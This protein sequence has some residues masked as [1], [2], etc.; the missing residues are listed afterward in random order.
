MGVLNEQYW[1]L[2]KMS[3]L[4]MGVLNCGAQIRTR[5]MLEQVYETMERVHT[6][7]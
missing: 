1:L 7:C 4:I 2:L 5:V 3:H 6:L